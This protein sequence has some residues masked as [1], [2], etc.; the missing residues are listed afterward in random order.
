MQLFQIVRFCFKNLNGKK[1]ELEYFNRCIKIHFQKHMKV[2]F[3]TKMN[4][5]AFCMTLTGGF[6]C[7]ESFRDASW[8]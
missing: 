4:Y 7:A 3:Q 2:Y 5:F 1:N 8:T 6:L